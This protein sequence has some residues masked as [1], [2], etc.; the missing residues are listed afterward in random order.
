MTA[1]NGS[2]NIAVQGRLDSLR[3]YWAV[4]GSPTWHPETVAGI[5]F[6]RGPPGGFSHWRV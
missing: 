1:S 6:R 4:N 5:A 3:C 2:V